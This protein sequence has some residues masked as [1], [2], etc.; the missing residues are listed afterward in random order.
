MIIS[1]EKQH[2]LIA[3]STTVISMFHRDPTGMAH[4]FLH[5]SKLDQCNYVKI[6]IPGI[7]LYYV[8][9]VFHNLKFLAFLKKLI[10]II[11]VQALSAIG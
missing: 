4:T 3:V 2:F 11:L 10:V 8:K 1:S 9:V 7:H 6:T 5:W